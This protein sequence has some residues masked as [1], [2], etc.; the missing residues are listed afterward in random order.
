MPFLLIIFASVLNMGTKNV[1]MELSRGPK[2]VT[3]VALHPGTVDTDMMRPY[4]DKIP[5][6]RTLFTTDKSV[7]KMMRII[8]NLREDDNGKFLGS[9]GKEIVF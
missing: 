8:E 1:S 4:I 7:R 6:G 9:D 5:E 2:K 3:C